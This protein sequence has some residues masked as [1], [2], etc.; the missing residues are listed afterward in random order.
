MASLRDIPLLLATFATTLGATIAIELALA[1]LLFGVR[2]RR[3]CAV[4][5]LA[6]V[7]TNPVV[8]AACLILSWSPADPIPSPSWA[9]ILALEAAAVLVEAWVYRQTGAVRRPL[10]AS[11]ALNAASFGIGCVAG[12]VLA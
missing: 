11:L 10:L 9:A 2:Q 7:V 4:V 5:A 6:Q 12:L 8:E 3:D 1:W